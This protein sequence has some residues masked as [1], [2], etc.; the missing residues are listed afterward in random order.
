MKGEQDNGTTNVPPAS[1]GRLFLG[2]A[3]YSYPHWRK[4]FYPHGLSHAKELQ[5]Y[6]QTF[7]ACEINTTFYG[8]PSEATIAT[9]IAQ[10]QPV[11]PN[12]KFTL[13]MKKTIT[14]GGEATRSRS[15]NTSSNT[16][17]DVA[18]EFRHPS[19]F[20][21]ETYTFLHSHGWILVLH[22]LPQTKALS[23]E[24]EELPSPSCVYLRL[25]GL[26]EEH[27]WDYSR[28]ELALYVDKEEEEGGGQEEEEEAAAVAAAAAAAAAAEEEEEEEEED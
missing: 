25:H 27:A 14:H 15:A 19:W 3:G 1:H 18:F 5:F 6:A 13:K 23:K 22:A 10:V 2:T 16:P 4:S 8:V 17:T 20:C 24:I 11:N 21:A 12:F 26:K 7:N 28:E 9:W